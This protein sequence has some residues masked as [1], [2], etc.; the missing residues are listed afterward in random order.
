MALLRLHLH[1]SASFRDTQLKMGVEKLGRAQLRAAEMVKGLEHKVRWRG[2]RLFNLVKKRPRGNLITVYN[3]LKGT[4]K[5]EG[6]KFFLLET[7]DITRSNRQF[8][9]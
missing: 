7:D 5:Y 2:L 9:A 3:Y 1:F 8:A 4:Y 6:E